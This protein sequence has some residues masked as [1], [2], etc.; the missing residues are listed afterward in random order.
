MIEVRTSR[1]ARRYRVSSL[2]IEESSPRNE[3]EIMFFHASV[4][5]KIHLFRMHRRGDNV[6][7]ITD[8]RPFLSLLQTLGPRDIV[9]VWTLQ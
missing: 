8:S 2:E 7:C 4:K 9:I 3:N 1:E 5:F 6:P